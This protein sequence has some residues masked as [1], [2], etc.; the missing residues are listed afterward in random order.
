MKRLILIFTLL[1]AFPALA[2][3]QN[4]SSYTAPP[5]EISQVRALRDTSW[6][7]VHK[8]LPRQTLFSICKAYDI[9]EGELYEA[10]RAVLES[11]LKAGTELYIP[12]HGNAGADNVAS[13]EAGSQDDPQSQPDKGYTI[14]RVKWYETLYSI[15]RKYEISP[16]SIIRANSLTRVDL[17]TGQLLRIPTDNYQNTVEKQVSDEYS[18]PDI[19]DTPE[20]DQRIADDLTQPDEDVTLPDDDIFFSEPFSGKARIALLL[21]F[22]SKAA[23]PSSNYLDFYSGVLLA[24]ERIKSQGVDADLRVIDISDY[25]DLS[26]LASDAFLG[27]RDFVI[28]PVMSSDIAQIA[29]Y[30]NDRRIPLISPMDQQAERLVPDNPFLVQAPVSAE[31]QI[32]KLVQSMNY[33]S[34]AE[35]NVVVIHEKGTDTTYFKQVEAALNRAGIPFR[36]FSYGILE[37]RRIDATLSSSYLSGS[38]T[39]HI[40]IASEKESFAS[41][42]VRNISLLSSRY[43]I[44]GYGSNRLR[45]FETIEL[46][47]YQNVSMHFSL[48]YYVD[49]SRPEVKDFVF[50]YR[51]LFNT[52]PGAYAFQGYDLTSYFTEALRKYGRYFN[53]SLGD[54]DMKLLQSNMHY[55]KSSPWGGYVNKATKNIVYLDDYSIACE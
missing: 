39:N 22:N 32:A 47:A 12:I 26:V 35:D 10:N 55:E 41:D 17:R 13:Q 43:D 48:G 25:K 33:S 28:G 44:V 23:S 46:E 37:G 18:G 54:F 15:S 50:K 2:L 8:V 11:G 1:C 38:K 21:P 14:H 49:Y 45:N 36:T 3:A 9:T 20:D 40:I 7:Y 42:A 6:F 5:V 31:N 27:D 19:I 16:E 24:L 29:A 4:N 34:A 53:R 51:A 52:E 30:C